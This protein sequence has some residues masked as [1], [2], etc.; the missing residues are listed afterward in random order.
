MPLSGHTVEVAERGRRGATLA[1]HSLL[2]FAGAAL[3]PLVFGIVLDA[4][5]G[6]DSLWSWGFGF[7]AMGL[8]AALGPAVLALTARKS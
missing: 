3:G 6:S 1:A 8:T 5:G 4:A 2:G 7:A